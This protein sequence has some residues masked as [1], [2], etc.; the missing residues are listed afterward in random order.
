VVGQM[1]GGMSRL[2]WTSSRGYGHSGIPGHQL[3][4]VPR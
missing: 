1:A 2:M 3:N 4:Y